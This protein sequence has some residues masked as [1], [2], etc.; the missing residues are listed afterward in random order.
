MTDGIRWLFWYNDL[1]MR[2]MFIE[3]KTEQSEEAAVTAVFGVQGAAI[4]EVNHS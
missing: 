1:A 3:R 4:W 2:A